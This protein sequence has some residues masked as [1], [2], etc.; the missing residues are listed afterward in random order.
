MLNLL[1][2]KYVWWR[3]LQRGQTMTEY[4][5]VVVTIAIA[6]LVAY[7]KFGTAVSLDVNTLASDL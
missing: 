7:Q 3:E 5:L 2:S 6:A 4:V 1:I